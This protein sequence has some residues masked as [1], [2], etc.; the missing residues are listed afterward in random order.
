MLRQL[1]E[2][3]NK[4]GSHERKMTPSTYCLDF[5]SFSAHL[6]HQ[7]LLIHVDVQFYLGYY[8]EVSVNSVWPSLYQFPV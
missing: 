5:K 2:E 7:L 1:I 3:E 8:V 6:F 4:G